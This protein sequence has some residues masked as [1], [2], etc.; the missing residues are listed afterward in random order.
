MYNIFRKPI[1]NLIIVNRIFRNWSIYPNGAF[2]SILPSVLKNVQSTVWHWVFLA[3]KAEST[4]VFKCT[5]IYTTKSSCKIYRNVKKMPTFIWKI[6]KAKKSWEKI[7][8][9]N[10]INTKTTTTTNTITTTATFSKLDRILI[11]LL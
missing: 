6:S 3:Y 8:R 2:I 11:N 4:Q 9:R 7:F 5:Y 1:H 10:F